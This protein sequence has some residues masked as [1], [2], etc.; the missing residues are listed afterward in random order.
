M[1]DNHLSHS[2]DYEHFPFQL[3]GVLL[4][5]STYSCSTRHRT[6]QSPAALAASVASLWTP[7]DSNSPD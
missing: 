2:Y 3:S 1:K 4:L 6:P 5:I 7:L